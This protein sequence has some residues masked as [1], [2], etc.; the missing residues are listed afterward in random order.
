MAAKDNRADN[1]P[2][3]SKDEE[4]SSAEKQTRKRAKKPAERKEADAAPKEAKAGAG[5]AEAPTETESGKGIE[6]RQGRKPKKRTFVDAETGKAIAKPKQGG[7]GGEAAKAARE[8]MHEA[9]D[10]AAMPFRI[11]AVALWALGLACEIMAIL[12]ANGTLLLPG[13]SSTAW[14]VIWIITDLALVVTG[15]Q[16]W[17]HANHLAPASKENKLA[18]WAQTELGAIIAAIA[19]APIVIVLL[20]SKNLDKRAKAIGSAAAAIAL[21]AAVGSGIDWHPATQEDL[22]EAEAGAAVLSDDGLCYWTPFGK[23]YHFNPDCQYIKNSP[24]IYSGTVSD[25]IEAR[26][27]EGCSGCTTEDGTDIL[28]KSDPAAVAEAAARAIGAI[29]EEADGDTGGNEE[30]SSSASTEESAGDLQKAA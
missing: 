29:G 15:S 5:E 4:G 11:G 3:R 12:T 7:A 9:R 20:A 10:G 28:S 24:T 22:D 14:I 16:L 6:A 8:E 18:Y 13:V 21:V 30:G 25:A 23:V 27:N 19:F 2:K 17:K 26:R 1:H